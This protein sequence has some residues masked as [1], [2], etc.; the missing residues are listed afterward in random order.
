[1]IPSLKPLIHTLPLWL[2][3]FFHSS[4]VNILVW[5][6]HCIRNHFLSKLI[7]AYTAI[8]FF[9]YDNKHFFTC[10]YTLILISSFLIISIIAVCLRG[11]LMMLTLRRG[12]SLLCRGLP[13]LT[14]CV[15]TAVG[16][17][18]LGHC[19]W[20]YGLFLRVCVFLCVSFSFQLFLFISLFIYILLLLAFFFRSSWCVLGS[21]TVYRSRVSFLSSECIAVYISWNF[22][23]S[24]HR[25]CFSYRKTVV[26][27]FWL[28]K[29][30]YAIYSVDDT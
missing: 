14:W 25:L 24:L 17:L 10:L 12:E 11:M 2:S 6:S 23:Y 26:D 9:H 30:I 16:Y 3:V 7:D 18:L 28:P 29:E 20:L 19:I 21:R 8:Y 5:F 13:C 15:Q 4:S 27:L 1:M 22:R